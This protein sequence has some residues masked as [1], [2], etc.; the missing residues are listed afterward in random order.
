MN[1]RVIK[2]FKVILCV[3][4][5]SSEL[6][7]AH[8]YRPSTLMTSNLPDYIQLNLTSHQEVAYLHEQ[9]S[10]VSLFIFSS[11][12]QQNMAA[13][14]DRRKPTLPENI[15]TESD[16]QMEELLRK[17]IDTNVTLER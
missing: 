16:L 9:I 2:Y 8:E 11:E 15:I 13:R 7:T 3:S 17:Q 12:K 6:L 10:S 1:F 14:R 5:I 4:V